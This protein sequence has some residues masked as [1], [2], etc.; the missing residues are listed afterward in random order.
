MN[1]ITRIAALALSVAAAGSAF[2]ESPEM[3]YVKVPMPAAAATAAPRSV[4]VT[5]GGTADFDL[6]QYQGVAVS[7]QRSRAEVRAETLRAIARG[8][9][10]HS[11]N[12][13]AG[14]G[15]IVR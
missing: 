1:R 10:R 14:Y 13:Y 3:D 15:M 7:S 11:A 2:A 4:G 12:E 6:S 8:E 9:L 5:A